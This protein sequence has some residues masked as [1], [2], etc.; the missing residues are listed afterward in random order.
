[1]SSKPLL[2]M[3]GRRVVEIFVT[4]NLGFR[5]K[6]GLLTELLLKDSDKGF[7]GV[8]KSHIY[9]RTGQ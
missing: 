9:R 1:M 7:G 8:E 2:F 6:A 5:R 3:A 4:G